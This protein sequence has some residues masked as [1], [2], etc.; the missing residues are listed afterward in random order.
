MP[1]LLPAHK[2]REGGLRL[3]EIVPLE[4]VASFRNGLIT[5][6]LDGHMRQQK[7]ARTS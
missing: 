2:Q 4:A 5:R 3:T 7:A 1:H 6:K